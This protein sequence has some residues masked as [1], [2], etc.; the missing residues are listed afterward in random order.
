MQRKLYKK[1]ERGLKG[2]PN[3]QV[4]E[5]M[6][7]VTSTGYW[8]DSPDRNN[9][10]NVIPSNE[11][12][13]EGMDIPLMGM[14]NLGNTQYMTPGNNYTF[15]GSYVTETPIAKQ[16]GMY[17]GA[18]MAH[19]GALKP[20]PKAKDGNPL[21][22]ALVRGV[23][24]AAE[25]TNNYIK[26]NIK[27]FP[28]NAQIDYAVSQLKEMDPN[29][30]PD[31]ETLM[32]MTA[33]MENDYGAN[34]NAYNR[35]YTNSFMSIDKPALDDIYTPRGKTY[36]KSQQKIIDSLKKQGYTDRAALE[37]ALRNDDPFAAMLTAR[38]VY[39][40]S[41]EALPDMSNPEAVF[42]YFGKN[43]NKYGYR[44]HMSDEEAYNKFLK[45]WE[46]YGKK[47]S[48]SKG[49]M[50]KGGMY[51]GAY[52]QVGG[53]LVPHDISVPDLSRQEGG[54][55][56]FGLPL[57]EQNIY[58]LPEY[59]QPINPM[60][61]EILPD[62]QRPNLG[63]DTNATEYKYTYG[64]DEGDVDVP[65]IV[66]GQYIGDQALDRYRLTGERFK[67]MAD[68]GSYSKFYDQ[69]GQ[70]GLMQEKHGGAVKKV[71][72]KSLPKNWKSQ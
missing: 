19:G 28:N 68:P 50:A 15:P 47:S 30:N 8:P 61:G 43:Y 22:E 46:K 35:N 62:P 16:G 1:E 29:Y 44:K 10:F 25:P 40:M 60:T 34:P 52:K 70:L 37:K 5:M 23:K 12:T 32:K 3:Y 9:D 18:Y 55:M 64:F 54:E 53:Q 69:I 14:D 48:T 59:V 56:P 71:K 66:A 57:K 2:G 4:S 38:S 24:T 39:Y 21:T 45:G 31:V 11:I 13:M 27:R 65:S 49:K 67:T 51:L 58:T 26:G 36:N 20:L 7:S 33:W 72:I 42:K 17:L 41:P 63:M 6:G